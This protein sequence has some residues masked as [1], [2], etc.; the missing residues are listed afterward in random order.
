MSTD[1]GDPVMTQQQLQAEYEKL[2][3]VCNISLLR[4]AEENA[5]M[6]GA[7]A[8]FVDYSERWYRSVLNAYDELAAARIDLPW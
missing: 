1:E 4:Q 7:E 2:R 3:E 8:G 6:D 5:S